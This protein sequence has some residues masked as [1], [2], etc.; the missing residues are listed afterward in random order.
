MENIITHLIT[1]GSPSNAPIVSLGNDTTLCAGSTLILDATTT[2]GTYIWQDNST[3]ATLNIAQ[4]GIYWVQVT[5][6]GCIGTD[7]I[8]V[9][10]TTLPVISL[11]NDTTLCQGEFIT[12][13]ATTLNATYLWQDSTSNP[14]I[15][16][17]QQGVYWVQVATACGISYDTVTV[18]FNALPVVSLGNDTA[19]CQGTVVV[20]DV[21]TSGAT[22]IWQ[23]NS[24]N[25]TL[26]VTQPGVYWVQV[27]VSGCS[28]ADSILVNYNTFPIVDLGNDITLC[29]GESFTLDVTTANATY[30]WQDNST[31]AVFTGSQPGVFWVNVTVSNCT[32]T[33]TIQVNYNPLPVVS[34]GN[35]LTLC[36]GETVI[37]DATS[38]NGTY[39]WQDNSTGATFTV[40]IQG[41]YWVQ[42]TVDGCTS[43]DSI[44]I[45]FNPLPVVSL[46]NDQQLC[47]GESV[48]LDVSAQNATYLWSDNSTNSNLTI[49]QQGIYWV[50][51]TINNCTSA[52]TVSVNFNALPVFDLGSDTVLCNGS[53]I[54]LDVTTT[55]ATYLWQDNST[56]STFT[57]TEPGTFNVTVT[58]ENCTR[59][60]ELTADFRN[61]NIILEMPNVFTPNHDGKNDDFY[62]IQMEGIAKATLSVFDRWGKEL[63]KGDNLSEGWNGK[64]EGNAC[65]DGTYLWLVIYTDVNNKENSLTGTVMLLK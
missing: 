34:F 10:Y 33:D 4:P 53:S 59:T 7:T 9:D 28:S 23:D 58:V 46:G 52:D 63:F 60:D 62:P 50:A 55:N 11:G 21:T 37:L 13:D 54:L 26:N 61:C 38:L 29:D 5:A 15:S 31:N 12:L 27:T 48:T 64:Y 40:A 45:N 14:I 1:P 6:N 18:N 43:S 16:V 35:D 19:V 3:G 2:N 41:V 22:Y 42:V 24:T 65:T 49:T 57:I 36:D 44:S 51:V 56:G 20:L 32:S 47:E 30:N 17:S 8:V 25:S 39:Q